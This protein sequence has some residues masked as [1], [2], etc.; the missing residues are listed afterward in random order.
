M[1]ALNNNFTMFC[2]EMSVISEHKTLW[3][4]SGHFWVVPTL[5]PTLAWLGLAN[6]F[7]IAD[8]E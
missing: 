5:Y 7:A 4:L 3:L 6:F 1:K 8:V 2:A